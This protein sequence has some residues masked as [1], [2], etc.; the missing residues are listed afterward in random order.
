MAAPFSVE[1]QT[2]GSTVWSV[3]ASGNSIQSG[4]LTVAGATSVTGA[5]T[6]TGA[7]T[8]S[9]VISQGGGINSSSSVKFLTG[10]QVGAGS[11][12]ILGTAASGTQLSDLTR[13][14]MLYFTVTAGGAAATWLIG[15]TSAC[16][17]TVWAAATT[18]VGTQY[19]F[20]LPAGW[21]AQFTG[22]AGITN[23][24]AVSC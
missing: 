15:S 21:F 4:N 8:I 5:T 3:D 6:I 23:Q 10:T 24:N 12:A 9:G 18:N 22:T 16:N 19:A 11:A 2:P 1:S 7:A 20:R 17:A 13:D 14:Y